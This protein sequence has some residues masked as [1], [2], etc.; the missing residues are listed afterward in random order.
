MIS[1]TVKNQ[2]YISNSEAKLFSQL[3]KPCPMFPA[4]KNGALRCVTVQGSR[5][6][7]PACNNKYDFV[8]NPPLIYYCVGG[9]WNSFSLQGTVPNAPWPDCAGEFYFLICYTRNYRL[10]QLPNSYSIPINKSHAK[11]LITCISPSTKLPV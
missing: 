3:G 6:C 8:F 9:A 11:P 2:P 4:P 1:L 10:R 7:A 5:I